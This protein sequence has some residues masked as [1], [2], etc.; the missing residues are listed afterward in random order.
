MYKKIFKYFL[1]YYFVVCIL[2][3]VYCFECFFY[4]SKFD[5]FKKVNDNI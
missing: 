2:Y 1:V 4:S 3:N 5:L